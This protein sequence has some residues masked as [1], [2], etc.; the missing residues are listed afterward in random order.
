MIRFW[1][2]CNRWLNLGEINIV[3]GNIFG[4]TIWLEELASVFMF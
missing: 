1:I 3:G 4:V 2:E